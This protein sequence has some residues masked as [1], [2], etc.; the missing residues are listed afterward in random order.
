MRLQSTET[1][2]DCPVSLCW[3]SSEKFRAMLWQLYAM[4]AV[5]REELYRRLKALP[6][7]KFLKSWYWEACRSEELSLAGYRCRFCGAQGK[8]LEVHHKTYEHR[9]R[10][11]E[12]IE[13]LRAICSDCHSG[14]HH[15]GLNWAAQLLAFGVNNTEFRKKRR[16]PR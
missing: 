5:A 6:Y 12:H 9:G 10:D 13:T 14:T 15:G 16:L 7:E 4:P 8:K 1:P 2:I 11:H 3:Q